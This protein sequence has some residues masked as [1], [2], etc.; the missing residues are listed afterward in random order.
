MTLD[1][2]LRRELEAVV[3]PAGLSEDPVDQLAYSRDLWPKGLLWLRAGRHTVHPP[4]AVV[5]PS[6]AEQ[7]GDVLRCLGA[8]GIPVV[9][10][11]AGSGVC[12]GTLPLRGDVVLDLKKLCRLRAVDP[13]RRLA[14]VEA[15]MIGEDYE[16]ALARRGFTGGHFPSS[17]YCSSVG[18]WIATRGAGQTS[19][20][21]GKIEDMVSDVGVVTADGRRHVVSGPPGRGMGAGFAQLLVG[22][23]GV[24]GVITDARLRVRPAPESRRF[25]A[26]RFSSLKSGLDGVR[27]LLQAGV[28]PAVVRL[29]DA[30]DSLILRMGSVKGDSPAA[31]SLL[32][33]L[34]SA[35]K[36]LVHGMKQRATRELLEHPE[37]PNT[38]LDRLPDAA[39]GGC[40]LILVFE[41]RGT[42]VQAEERLAID[43]LADL[44]T[45]M[46]EPLARQWFE[47]RYAISYRQSGVFAGGGFNDTMEV[48]ATWDRLLPV[49]VAVRNALRRKVL[50]LAH[51]SHAYHEG[52]S[53]YFTFVGAARSDD[54]A[55]DLYDDTWRTAL[56]AVVET[57]GVI[58]HHHGVG[59]AKAAAMESEYGG[60]LHIAWAVKRVL[61][62]AGILNP[63]KLLGPRE[64]SSLAAIGDGAPIAAPPAPARSDRSRNAGP[65]VRPM[66]ES[67]QPRTDPSAALR[68]LED[69]LPGGVVAEGDPPV[70]TATPV[71][72][73]EVAACMRIATAHGIPVVA[74]SETAPGRI[75]PG[76]AA[77]VLTLERMQSIRHLSEEAL[78][79]HAEA[80]IR[81]RTLEEQ[82]AVHALSLGYA[83]LPDL[84]PKLG[85]LL[86]GRGWG[87]ASALYGS[88]DDA[89]IG[90]EAVL[91]RGDAIRIKA[92]PRRAAGPDLMQAFVGG[93]G[94]FGVITAA[95]LRVHR[96]P[97][98]RHV[99]GAWFPGPAPALACLSALLADS[100][101][102]AAARVVR[103]GPAWATSSL[104][105]EAALVLAFEGHT[106]VVDGFVELARRRLAAEGGTE[107]SE[108]DPLCTR[109]PLDLPAE[110]GRVLE[111]VEAAGRWSD[112][113][114]L[115]REAAALAAEDLVSC[116]FAGGL[117][118]GGS[119]TWTFLEPEKRVSDARR[120]AFRL[121]A[122]IAAAG[123]AL[124]AHRGPRP[125]PRHLLRASHGPLRPWMESLKR[126]LDPAGILNPG[127]L[128]LV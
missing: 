118:E 17:M 44:G 35:G 92:A 47:H 58:S 7:V 65:P 16:Q 29:Y 64:K 95:Y 41:G 75:P 116:R 27:R 48:A 99:L 66:T 53:I 49:Y 57:G 77:I 12:G 105:G 70:F 106:T 117:P 111:R 72:A 85:G 108:D 38:A 113:L 15:G 94:A 93:E 89:C 10:F 80:G 24:Y 28:R 52:C 76:S 11:G 109:D 115:D 100:V 73:P 25:R 123:L 22:S 39:L 127:T 96:P 62:P 8:R 124:A 18:G 86:G 5:W 74:R 120:P 71:D 110:T 19:T 43:L 114:A 69:A 87:E 91:P 98:A 88:F 54:A 56:S 23:E 84:S 90:L 81:V 33:R 21:Y 46:G 107:A 26:L 9:P 97:K 1:P 125:L 31:G 32:A 36:G 82:L 78:V 45:D 121:V 122:R 4:Q 37:L 126:E 68:A 128:G 55:L 67:R 20:L 101:R 30:I 13:E 59:V 83:L 60:A 61:D 51:F 103:P 14:D 3:G 6:S 40:I 79:V 102:P 104:R 119:A 2:K 42:L 50:V 63:G 112:L 34:R